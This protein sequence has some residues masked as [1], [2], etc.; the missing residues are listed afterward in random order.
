MVMNREGKLSEFN[1]DTVRV[2][3]E[4]NAEIERLRERVDQLEHEK[5]EILQM[6]KTAQDVN[7]DYAGRLE[8][9]LHR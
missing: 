2:L 4:A 3:S 6:F 1:L 8:D 9:A 5:D 7:R